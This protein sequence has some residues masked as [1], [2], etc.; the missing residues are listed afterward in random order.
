MNKI[1]FSCR[2]QLGRMLDT[3][4]HKYCS[5]NAELSLQLTIHWLILWNMMLNKLTVAQQVKKFSV[6]KDYYSIQTNATSIQFHSHPISFNIYFN[7]VELCYNKNH[8]SR[9]SRSI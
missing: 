7:M 3:S 8:E 5:R 6:L 2:F 4:H 1:K 9:Y